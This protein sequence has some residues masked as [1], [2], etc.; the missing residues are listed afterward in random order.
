MPGPS[1]DLLEHLSQDELDEAID[2]AQTDEEPRLVRRLCLIKNIY[3]GDTLTDAAARVGVSTPTASRWLD[4]WND[5]A[6]DGLRPEFGGGRPPKLND[7]QRER[8]QQVLKKHPLLTIGQ[9][10]ELIED[11][12]DVSY[13]QRHIS[14]LINKLG[15]NHVT[16]QPESPDRPDD[17]KAQL[18]ERLEAALADLDDDAVTDG[19]V[20]VG[21]LDEA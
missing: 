5:G 3:F 18:E 2:Q 8:L 10:Q 17:A 21:F 1:K 15:L 7:H 6:V 19:G 14:R 16:P 11:G 13:S 20:V 4:R 9:V 12:F